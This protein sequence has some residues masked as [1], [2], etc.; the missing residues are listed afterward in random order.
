MH[1]MHT[2]KTF[3]EKLDGNYTKIQKAIPNKSVAFWAQPP[4]SKTIQ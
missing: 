2:K 3:R 1:H 4:I